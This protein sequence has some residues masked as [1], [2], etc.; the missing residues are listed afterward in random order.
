MS[1]HKHKKPCCWKV[2][3]LFFFTGFIYF[4]AN[5][6]LHGIAV[7]KQ[8]KQVKLM[9]DMQA[10][11]KMQMEYYQQHQPIDPDKVL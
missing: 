8:Y 7:Y 1:E 3:W 4:T 11:I 10:A 9:N 2:A 6:T 5:A